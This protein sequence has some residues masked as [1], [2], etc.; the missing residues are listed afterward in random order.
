MNCFH[1]QKRV[2]IYFKTIFN[3]LL[4]KYGI[5][6]FLKIIMI[7]AG[8]KAVKLPLHI[9]VAL[10]IVTTILKRNIFTKALE[11]L[12]YFPQCFN[13][14]TNCKKIIIDLF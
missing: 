11:T 9:A 14:L 4:F 7:S 1:N 5:A 6:K 12:I 8:D 2:N 13:F 3:H 10:Q